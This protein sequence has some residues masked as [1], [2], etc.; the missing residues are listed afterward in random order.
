MDISMIRL[1]NDTINQPSYRGEERMEA[2]RTLKFESAA[3]ISMIDLLLKIIQEEH[4][5][6]YLSTDYS[7]SNEEELRKY[8]RKKAVESSKE[9]AKLLAHAAG[10][11][12]T[13]VDAINMDSDQPY[14]FLAKRVSADS[15]VD[16]MMTCFSQKLSMPVEELEEQVEVTWLIG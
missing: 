4:L 9:N 7:L 3:K 1:H 13:G 15:E 14:V 16:G 12:I 10:K 2:S 6:A 11:E 5:D 8:L